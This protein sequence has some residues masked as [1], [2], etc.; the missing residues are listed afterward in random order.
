M[1]T[2]EN[3]NS[4]TFDV[5]ALKDPGNVSI[6]FMTCVLF[7]SMVEVV[8]ARVDEETRRKMRLLDT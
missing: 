2:R 5:R 3:D 1:N 4:I 8:S 7:V 6:Y